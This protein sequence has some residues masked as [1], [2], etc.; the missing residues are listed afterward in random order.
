MDPETGLI[1][2]GAA[3]MVAKKILGPTAEYI[4]EGLQKWTE[5]RVHNVRR[6][7]DNA[8]RKLGG[9]IDEEG[10]VPPRVLGRILDEGSYS[11]DAIATD[12]LGGILASSRSGISRDDRGVTFVALVARLSAYELRTHYILYAAGSR[13]LV[14]STANFGLSSDR[15]ATRLFLDMDVYQE[16]MDLVETEDLNLVLSH[17]IHGLKTAGL[18][19]PWF[20]TG[21]TDTLRRQHRFIPSPGIIYQ[22]SP[23]GIELFL[24]AHALPN[25]NI[26]H[27]LEGLSDRLETY[28][29]I[30]IRS[31]AVKLAELPAI[32]TPAPA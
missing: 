16:A 1:V 21:D 29:P 28:T 18:I 15:D 3:A 31:P 32:D 13:G 10:A 7:F 22:L 6:I 8:A 9:E 30:V 19:D 17:A 26:N 24:W 4:G 2:F 12:Y 14:G 20:G 23:L 25:Q 27:F 5:H 11:A